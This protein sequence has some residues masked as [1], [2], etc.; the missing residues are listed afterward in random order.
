MCLHLRNVQS[1]PWNH[2]RVYRIYCQLRLNLPV[3]PH[4]R[5]V[6]ERSQVLQPPTQPNRVC[7][8]DFMHDQLGDARSYRSLNVLDDLNRELMC[9]QIDF[10]LPTGRVTQALDRVIEWLGKPTAIHSDNGPGY[11]S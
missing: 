4:Q 7:F 6:R 11:I 3:K 1:K 10:S 8:M 2:K 5:I 9:A